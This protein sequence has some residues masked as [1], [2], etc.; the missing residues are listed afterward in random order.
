MRFCIAGYG[1]ISRFHRDALL[2]ID[3]VSFDSV[4]GRLIDP[5]CDFT[6]T[7]AAGEHRPT[8]AGDAARYRVSGGD[9]HEPA[10][11]E[12]AT[13]TIPDFGAPLLDDRVLGV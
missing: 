8:N 4:V 2:Q 1:S 9:A 6:R 5:A 13:M 3:G 11:R 7:V 12:G 10:N